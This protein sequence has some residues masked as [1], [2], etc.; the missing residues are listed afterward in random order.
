M[1]RIRL[2][3]PS[4]YKAFQAPP[5][6]NDDE[7]VSY[8]DLTETA[9]RTMLGSRTPYRKVGFILQLGYFRYTGRFFNPSQFHKQDILFVS[10]MLKIGPQNIDLSKYKEHIRAQDQQKIMALLGFKFFEDCEEAK[11]LLSQE[12]VRLVK[13]HIRPKMMV[14]YLSAFF[15]KKKIEVPNYKRIEEEIIKASS[16]FEK[17]L[18]SV[19]K[20]NITKEECDALDSLLPKSKNTNKPESSYAHA[21]IVALRNINLSARTGK[22]KE[23]VRELSIIKGL[24]EKTS[25]PMQS[26][27]M[28]KATLK[29]YAVWTQKAKVT[30]LMQLN[31][32]HEKYLHLVS[33]VA[34]QYYC[35][36]DIFVDILL[37]VAQSTVTHIEK[38][39][40]KEDKNA[41]KERER[42]TKALSTSYKD[43][44]QLLVAINVV[45]NKEELSAEEKVNEIKNI[46]GDGAA[47]DPTIT[48]IIDKLNEEI[49]LSMKNAYF[50]TALEGQSIR[51][52]K[53]LSPILKNIEFNALNSSKPLLDAILHFKNSDGQVGNNPPCSF[54]EEVDLIHIRDEKGKIKQRLYKALLF[55][56]VSAAIKSGEVNLLHS[57]RYLSIE[58]YLINKK[59]W[60]DDHQN[61]INRAELSIY[62]D[63]NA[64]INPLKNK[65]DSLYGKVNESI[66]NGDNIHASINKDGDIVVKT[67][68]VDKIETIKIA[69]LLKQ[70]N[71]VSILDVLNTVD[72]I[73]KFNECL[74]HYSVTQKTKRPGSVIFYAGLIGKGCNIGLGKLAGVSKG[75]NGHT[76]ENTVNWYFTYDNLMLANNK[77]IAFINKLALPNLMKKTQG[78]LHTSSDGQKRNVDTDSIL[79][80]FSFKYHG[81]GRGVSIYDFI[82]ERNVLFHSLVMSS[83]EREAGY[84]IDGLM[85]NDEIRSDTHSTDTHGYTDLIFAIT[86]LLGISFAPRLAKLKK[87]ALYC[88]SPATRK[89][90]KKKGYSVLPDGA[91]D[92]E[93]IEENWDDIL[94]LVATI[95]LKEATAS[96]ILKRLS[97]YAKDNP[98]YK[99]LKEFGKLIKTIFLL[100]YMDDLDLRQAIQKQLNKIELSNKFSSAVFFDNNQEFKQGTREEQEIAMACKILLQNAIVL[101]NY[102]YLSHLL[103]TAEN[104]SK[105][106][107]LLKSIKN[108]SI[109]TWQHLNL[110]GEYDFRNRPAS[111]DAF[112]NIEKTLAWKMAQ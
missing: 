54:L 91:I 4:E 64:V 98:L 84:V 15:C 52:Q 33:F 42:A 102:L 35:R 6:F 12:V 3:S 36:Q 66:N 99:G 89:A 68:K 70:K 110:L 40:K 44:T 55:I 59:A 32:P 85:C 51:L 82:D 1:A 41:K 93:L 111:N 29:Y 7:K 71:Y 80:N 103:M 11:S 26:L 38:A 27:S 50:Y 62:S 30:Q 107:E 19:L 17:S 60:E 97:S 57:Y 88:V 100:T 61:Y 46:M 10:K 74:Q 18:I 76:L 13:Q 108:G 16:E 94:R 81:S 20:S 75:I 72:R 63:F 86:H 23:S 22:I 53:K 9:K 73:T 65:L 105:R 24:F 112:F 83:S 95:K 34:H 104:D 79:A 87:R 90:Y 14:Y 45:L 78:K 56:K 25:R 48:A 28:P 21:P 92:L 43:K 109:M 37:Q 106:G 8:F 49:S 5:I 77:I 101:W 39:G 96:Q 69:A 67:P 31:D 58:E 47:V 2:L